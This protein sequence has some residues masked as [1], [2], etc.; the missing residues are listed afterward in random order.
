MMKC[1]WGRYSM[2]DIGVGMVSSAA[3]QQKTQVLYTEFGAGILNI[4][5]FWIS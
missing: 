4:C 3:K 2:H 1:H 5:S